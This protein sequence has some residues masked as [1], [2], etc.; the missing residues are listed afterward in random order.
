V[1]VRVADSIRKCDGTSQARLC[2]IVVVLLSGGHL[3]F[4]FIRCGRVCGHVC[5]VAKEPIGVETAS[6]RM[7]ELPLGLPQVAALRHTFRRY[8][9]GLPEGSEYPAHARE[10][11]VCVFPSKRADQQQTPCCGVMP[12]VWAGEKCAIAES[13][14][15]GNKSNLLR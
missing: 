3:R 12:R 11:A 6:K 4:K 2:M 7:H 13:G 1:S 10:N 5:A 8:K 14:A 15:R 9:R